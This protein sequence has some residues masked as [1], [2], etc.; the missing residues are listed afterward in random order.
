MVCLRG[1][2][3]VG[4]CVGG[5]RYCG[6]GVVNLGMVWGACRSLVLVLLLGM[7]CG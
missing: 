4:C 3:A 6:F 5:T 2:F 7:L 1:G